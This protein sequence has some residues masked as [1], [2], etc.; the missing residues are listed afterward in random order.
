MCIGVAETI[1]TVKAER[2]TLIREE[3]SR[4]VASG[5]MTARSSSSFVSTR[6][7]AQGASMLELV[8]FDCG[9][10]STNCS[11]ELKLMFLTRLVSMDGTTNC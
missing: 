6:S 5:N 10:S 1:R 7:G 9:S 2:E 4:S 3:R 8:R 11:L